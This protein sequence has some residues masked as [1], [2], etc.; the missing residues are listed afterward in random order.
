MQKQGYTTVDHMNLYSH[1]HSIF[2]GN[3]K[4]G[5][6][7]GIRFGRRYW[8][9]RLINHVILDAL[10]YRGFEFGPLF[11]LLETYLKKEK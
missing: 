9:V 11:F 8:R 5:F 7:F 2:D 3:R 1:Y 6:A 4:F 10:R